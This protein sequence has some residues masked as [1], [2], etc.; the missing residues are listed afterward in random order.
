MR[1]KASISLRHMGHDRNEWPHGTHVA[2]WPHGMHASRFSSLMQSAQGF[3]K[4]VSVVC[5]GSE[6]T[7]VVRVFATFVSLMA[8]AA[9]ILGF[10]WVVDDSDE[11]VIAASEVFDDAAESGAAGDETNDAAARTPRQL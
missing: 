2:K 9:G 5:I 3:A 8:D 11:L 10:D 7:A 4:V 6:A 1:T